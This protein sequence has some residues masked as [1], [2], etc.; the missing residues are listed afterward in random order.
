[1][2][3]EEKTSEKSRTWGL[4]Y[5]YSFPSPSIL[6]HYLDT[7]EGA[8]LTQKSAIVEAAPNESRTRSRTWLAPSLDTLTSSSRAGMF[9]SSNDRAMQIST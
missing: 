9:K 4:L 6:L 3:L 8:F 2:D 1:M 7:K 5:S